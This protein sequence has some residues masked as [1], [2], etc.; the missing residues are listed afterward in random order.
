MNSV[1]SAQSS[2]IISVLTWN[3]FRE[4]CSARYRLVCGAHARDG[5][6]FKVGSV[7]TS[8]VR[9]PELT[10]PVSKVLFNINSVG[11]V[12]PTWTINHETVLWVTWSHS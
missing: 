1:F 3:S 7:P 12:K 10:G 2:V 4:W 5:V 11:M 9:V 6:S 8:S